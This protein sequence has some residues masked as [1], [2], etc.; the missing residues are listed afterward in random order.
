MCNGTV[1]SFYIQFCILIISVI[2]SFFLSFFVSRF[3]LKVIIHAILFYC[4]LPV[5]SILYGLNLYSFTYEK[6]FKLC[7]GL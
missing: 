3:A 1:G 4:V 2:S 6:S 5:R 7:I